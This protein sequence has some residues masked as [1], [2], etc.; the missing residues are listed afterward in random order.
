M[1]TDFLQ[2]IIIAIDGYFKLVLTSWPAV[3]LILSSWILFWYKEEIRRFIKRIKSIG[4]S[5]VDTYDNGPP[6]SKI[7]KIT[8]SEKS[9][10]FKIKTEDI[11]R[12]KS[13]TNY[14]LN[15]T[16]ALVKCGVASSLPGT[17]TFNFLKDWKV[18][19]WIGNN[20]YKKYKAYVKIKFI[21]NGFEKEVEGDYYGGETAWK[22]DA[23]TSIQA[24]GL[25]IPE[26]VKKIVREG[27]RI[28][29]QISCK[30]NDEDDNLIEEKFPQTYVYKPENNSWFLEP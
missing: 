4:P 24:P 12:E 9:E 28:K 5:G 10:L 3:I 6:D 23:L 8:E 14:A 19:F 27:K 30:I 13:Q 21:S 20:D 22:L 11:I 2:Q 1:I 16:T 25:G 26:E 15:G 7:G 17:V 29:I 18:W